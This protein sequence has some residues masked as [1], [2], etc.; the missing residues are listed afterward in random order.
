ARKRSISAARARGRRVGAAV[1]RRARVGAVPAARREWREAHS[2]VIIVLRRTN[3]GTT[4]ASEIVHTG[5]CCR[6]VRCSSTSRRL[7]GFRGSPGIGELAVWGHSWGGGYASVNY[8]VRSART[9]RRR[10]AGGWVSWAAKGGG[11]VGRA[12]GGA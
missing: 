9:A 1:D 2:R 3:T 12:P 10:R 7:H 6:C 4:R 11:V 5:G 8:G